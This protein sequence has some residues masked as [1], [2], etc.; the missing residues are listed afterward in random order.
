MP[1]PSTPSTA[2]NLF[3]VLALGLV[4]G[5]TEFLPISSS[6]HLVVGGKL[7]GM[8]S[9]QPLLLEVLLH[10]GTLVPVILHYRRDL[11]EI[12]VSL[13]RIVG[14]P[15]ARLWQHDRG[16]RLAVCVVLGTIPTGLVGV[17]LKDVFESAFGSLT[18]V[19]FTFLITGGI[20]MSV[21]LRGLK[22]EAPEEQSHLT[23][24]ATRALLV[25]LAQAMAIT[26]GISR[27]GT[28]IAAGMHLG[29][30]RVM[31]A[32]FS[33]LLSIPAICGAVVLH[34]R[35]AGGAAES[36]L[37][38]FAAGAA[39]AAASG[40]LALRW[41]VRLVRRGEM[42]WFSFYL[43]PLGLTVLVYTLILSK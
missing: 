38:V 35:K 22:N 2:H 25:G 41:L 36:D 39:V 15:P 29:I 23:L 42:H 26:P 34:L 37:L 10:V 30:E 5:L 1:T 17:L 3:A 18:A 13:T 24:T 33:F 12:L 9:E 32:R 14:Q 28:T 8:S 7:L 11:L 16:F 19:G 40:Y 27:S 6:G 43:W 31:A 21:R 4:Q 20:L